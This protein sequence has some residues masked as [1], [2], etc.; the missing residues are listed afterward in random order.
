MRLLKENRIPRGFTLIELM[1]A[2][3]IIALLVNLS[4][5]MYTTFKIKAA[6][7][8]AR[9][10]MNYGYT[11]VRSY[12]AANNGQQPPEFRYG[13][14][15]NGAGSWQCQQI[16]NVEIGFRLSDCMKVRYQYDLRSTQDF[17]NHGTSATSPEWFTIG[18]LSAL[19]P[20]VR[21][22]SGLGVSE[23]RCSHVSSAFE[24]YESL[25]LNQEK[26]YG[27]S[28]TFGDAWSPFTHQFHRNVHDAIY[29]C[30]R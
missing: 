23:D 16:D 17:P 26:E 21:V 19:G 24:Y 7:S 3:G 1:V 25:V 15:K 2:V 11:L 12:M 10:N 30:T 6:R 27:V 9:V 20:A 8:E 14:I 4:M 5:P 13:P 28:G 29:Q 18:A 22:G